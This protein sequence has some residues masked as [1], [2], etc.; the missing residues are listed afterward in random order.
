[1]NGEF[2]IENSDRSNGN[3]NVK[4]DYADVLFTLKLNQELEDYDV[5]LSGQFSSWQPDPRYKMVY[6]D[7]IHAYVAKPKFKQG[8]YDYSYTVV[9]KTGGS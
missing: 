2:V 4:S 5:Y 7:V 3:V 1:M 6:N 8:V 9:P